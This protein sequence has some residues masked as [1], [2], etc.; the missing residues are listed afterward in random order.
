MIRNEASRSVRFSLAYASFLFVLRRNGKLISVGSLFAWPMQA[1]C[2]CY[3]ATGTTQAVLC[4]LLRVA[5]FAFQNRKSYRARGSCFE[6][7][8]TKLARS[9]YCISSI[10]HGL[11]D[12]F[13][14]GWLRQALLV[15]T[16][17]RLG[18]WIRRRSRVGLV[19]H[20]C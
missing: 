15:V 20:S 8:G 14:C 2:S 12:S 3:V 13:L 19:G 10:Y 5:W 4:I 11:F 6:T 9:K 17:Y 7:V 16:L 1:F 18:A